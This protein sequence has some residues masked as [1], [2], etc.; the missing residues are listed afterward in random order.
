MTSEKHFLA[1]KIVFNPA[2]KILVTDKIPEP[3]DPGRLGVA[4]DWPP[5][6]GLLWGILLQENI[7]SEELSISG[8]HTWL[9]GCGT[10]AF[11][12][13]PFAQHEKISLV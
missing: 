8:S 10:L 6:V 4:A 9:S 7:P 1:L 12:F 13:I 11:R 3:E 5:F 2:L